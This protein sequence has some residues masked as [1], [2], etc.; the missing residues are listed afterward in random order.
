MLI[1]DDLE[2]ATQYFL[3]NTAAVDAL[4]P[5]FKRWF[6]AYASDNNSSSIREAITL[7]YLGYT[8]NSAKHGAD[9]VNPMTNQEVEVKPKYIAEGKT[10]SS[11]V[12]NFNDMSLELLEKKK[13]YSIIGSL[14]S[15]NRL[16]YVVEFPMSS[17]YGVLEKQ[18]LEKMAGKPG[19]RVVCPFSYNHYD[20]N[21]LK[22]HYYDEETAKATKIL[23]KPHQE[24]LNKH[25][26]K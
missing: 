25:Y 23:S 21:L 10:L 20:N 26:A 6:L 22:V 8:Q 14:F 24:M 1:K 2:I 15:P 9:G 5:T 12:G 4:G 19:K 11:S 3:G 17:I 16:I 13:D 18:I 7:H